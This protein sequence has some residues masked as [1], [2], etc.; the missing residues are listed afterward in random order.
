MYSKYIR[1]DGDLDL[2]FGQAILIFWPS[3]AI[4]R[5]SVTNGCEWRLKRFELNPFE[6]QSQKILSDLSHGWTFHKLNI[7]LCQKSDRNNFFISYGPSTTVSVFP[8]SR[9]EAKIEWGL[10]ETPPPSAAKVARR[11]TLAGVKS[12]IMGSE[13]DIVETIRHCVR[14]VPNAT[15]YSA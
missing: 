6:R 11:P 1:P 12:E 10:F 4:I 15:S 8:L 5:F 3:M 13:N 2:T 9:V 7:S 14:K